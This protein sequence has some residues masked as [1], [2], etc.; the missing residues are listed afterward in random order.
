M[1]ALGRANAT[2]GPKF[3]D[4]PDCRDAFV[5]A[6]ILKMIDETAREAGCPLSRAAATAAAAGGGEEGGSHPVANGRGGAEADIA[7][8]MEAL[9]VEAATRGGY[10]GA[11]AFET[12]SPAAPVITRRWSMAMSTCAAQVSALLGLAN[13][14]MARTGRG[15]AL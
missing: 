9:R 11:I 6:C 14:G 3:R 4:P 7:A 8:M 1:E 13:V 2:L 12:C 5:D 10:V 15:R